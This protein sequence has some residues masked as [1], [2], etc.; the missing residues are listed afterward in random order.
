MTRQ[1][2][3]REEDGPGHLAQLLESSCGFVAGNTPALGTLW[4]GAQHLAKR[5]CGVT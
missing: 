3:L 1:V 5:A 2:A 4:P